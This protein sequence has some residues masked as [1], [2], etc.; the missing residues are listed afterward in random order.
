ML[1]ISRSTVVFAAIP[2]LIM[3][4]SSLTFAS[5]V[6]SKYPVTFHSKVNTLICY[7]TTQDGRTLDLNRLCEKR[8]VVR[9]AIVNVAQE[10]DYIT[11]Q[12]TNKTDKTVYRTRINFNVL[13][14]KDAIVAQQA[15][16]AQPQ[17]LAPGQTAK[18][19]IFTPNNHDVRL[20]SAE[21]TEKP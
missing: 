4:V 7:M 10:G 21:G 9:I 20:T 18:F 17:I 1:K 13:D 6:N 3:N 11:G 16:V 14:D 15:V 2:I 19:E 12:V 8:Q 5:T